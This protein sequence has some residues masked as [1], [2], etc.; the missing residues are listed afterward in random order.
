LQVIWDMGV[1]GFS[2]EGLQK[3]LRIHLR[4]HLRGHVSRYPFWHVAAIHGSGSS[5]C[6]F[7]LGPPSPIHAHE[8]AQYVPT[9]QTGPTARFAHDLRSDRRVPQSVSHSDL[10][11]G[12]HDGFAHSRRCK[13]YYTYS[14]SC[15]GRCQTMSQKQ[16]P[17]AI[18]QEHWLGMFF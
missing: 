4:R 14:L 5:F 18:L 12:R 6:D 15:P 2:V 8:S 9:A 16:T 10:G 11:P 3:T 13:K 7:G 1:E 17:R